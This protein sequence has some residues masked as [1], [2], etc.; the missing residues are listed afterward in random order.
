MKKF[1]SENHRNL[2]RYLQRK[3]ISEDFQ[4]RVPGYKLMFRKMIRKNKD[5]L[6]EVVKS[7][8][9]AKSLDSLY[10]EED[11]TGS[12]ADML[13]EVEFVGSCDPDKPQCEESWL[14]NSVMEEHSVHGFKNIE[15]VSEQRIGGNDGRMDVLEETDSKK[16]LGI[17]M[18]NFSNGIGNTTRDNKRIISMT[19]DP[20]RREVSYDLEIGNDIQKSRLKET[21]TDLINTDPLLLLYYYENQLE[22]KGPHAMPGSKLIKL[23]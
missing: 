1:S 15:N 20:I 8:F 6:K 18:V 9:E 19:F 12:T 16:P 11:V 7:S 14:G 22:F 4:V 13:S 2:I 10:D 23:H 17:N 3:R 21:R 5:M